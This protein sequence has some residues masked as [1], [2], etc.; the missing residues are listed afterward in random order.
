MTPRRA[1]LGG[2]AL[3]LGAVASCAVP[4]APPTDAAAARARLEAVGIRFIAARELKVLLDR[5]EPLT[6][7]DARDEIHYR[8]GH[9]PGATSIPVEDAPLYAVDVRRPKRLLHPERLPA[10]RARL[11]VFYCGGFT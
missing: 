11:L 5:G 9:L 8:A 6:L 2:L 7:V 10:D 3:V 1:G 4:P